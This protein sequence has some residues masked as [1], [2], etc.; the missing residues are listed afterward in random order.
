MS[1]SK[2]EVVK[3]KNDEFELDVNVDPKEKTIW[4]SLDQ[5]STLFERDKS[6]ISRH[7][8]NIFTNGEINENSVVAFFATTALDGKIY[9]VKYYNLDI[10]LAVGYRVNSKR[11]IE[12][13]TWANGVLKQYLLQGYVINEER[14][15]VTNENYVRLINKVESIDER[16]KYIE[17][18]YKPK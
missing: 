9:N 14:T 2:Y 18:E 3:F 8:K 13:R 7:I 10:I 11:G 1:D 5:I 15:L 16:V 12:F 17:K 6:V 4:L